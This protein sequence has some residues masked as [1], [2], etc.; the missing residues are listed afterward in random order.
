M[1]DRIEKSIDLNVII[2]TDAC[3]LPRGELP[4][5]LRQGTQRVALDLFEQL[6]AADPEFA[7]RL[8]VQRLDGVR[9]GRVA[10]GER[11]ESLAVAGVSKYRFAQIP[12]FDLRFVAR[13][14]GARRLHVD[15]VMR[16]ERATGPVD[17]RV[18]KRALVNPDLE[19]V[20]HQQAGRF[21]EKPEDVHMRAGPV[22][23]L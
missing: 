1:R 6:S 9:D 3:P 18:V 5:G 14:S 10:F 15:A 21:A 20:G 4:V 13:P 12:G 8:A 7:H 19:I 16:R 11:E 2:D 22:G 17:L 23:P